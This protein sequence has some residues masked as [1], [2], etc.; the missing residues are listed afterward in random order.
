[1][2]NDTNI[3]RQHGVPA[4]IIGPAGE[5]DLSEGTIDGDSLSWTAEINTP[6][7]MTD[8]TMLA[9]FVAN[10]DGDTLTGLARM[11]QLGNGKL[12]GQ[13]A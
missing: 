2:W 10:I 1:M 3:F 5:S 4:V 7:P 6:M 12:L 11:G 13:R 8:D 9:V